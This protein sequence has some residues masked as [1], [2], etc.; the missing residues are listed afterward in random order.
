[1][2]ATLMRSLRR[3]V[4]TPSL[5]QRLEPLRELAYNLW[6]S[7]NHDAEDL[8]SRLDPVL[9]ERTHRNPVAL[10]GQIDQRVLEAASRNDAYLGH[11][12]EISTEFRRYMGDGGWFARSHAEDAQGLSI[13]YF[14]AEFGLAECIPTYSGGLGVL[15][16]DHLKS[17]SDLGLPLVG[18]SLAYSEGYFT[19]TLN[20]EGWQLERIPAV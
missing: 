10:L 18:I 9:W 5:P 19:Q 8:F 6:W 20:D 17:A 7:W 2:P 4:V 11:L 1:M 16:G 3:Y 14:S 12:D 15:A 13:A